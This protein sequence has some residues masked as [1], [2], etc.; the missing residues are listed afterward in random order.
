[1]ELKIL[2]I[3]DSRESFSDGETSNPKFRGLNNLA[4]LEYETSNMIC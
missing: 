4:Q 1:M 2:Q 3:Q